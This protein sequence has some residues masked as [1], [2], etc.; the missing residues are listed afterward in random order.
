[1]ESSLPGDDDHEQSFEP[2]IIVPGSQ[3]LKGNSKI[4]RS[5]KV[6]S[7]RRRKDLPEQ[8]LH[9]WVINR[10]YKGASESRGALLALVID[11]DKDTVR[12]LSKMFDMH[13]Y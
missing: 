5:Q 7:P 13:G 2:L 4:L 9:S 11:D 3:P 8:S 12:F 1:M 10:Y 6:A